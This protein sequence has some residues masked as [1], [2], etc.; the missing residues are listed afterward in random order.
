MKKYAELLNSLMRT[1]CLFG[2]G[3]TFPWRMDRVSSFY[4]A[5]RTGGWITAKKT[6]LSTLG[7]NQNSIASW[8]RSKLN[9]GWPVVVGYKLSA[10]SWHY[11]VAVGYRVRTRK[12]RRC[13]W[14]RCGKWKTEYDYQMNLNMGWGGSSNGY[15]SMKVF[16]AIAAVYWTHV[17]PQSRVRDTHGVVA[18][19]GHNTWKIRGSI[20]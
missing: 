6:A 12:F 7:I 15:Y 10:F 14:K 3:A 17:H 20:V 5:R 16:Y 9:Q 1:W 8:T 19:R 13:V 2:Q 11:P 18:L 4:K